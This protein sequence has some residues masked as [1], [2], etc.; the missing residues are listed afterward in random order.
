[1][2]TGQAIE[3]IFLENAERVFF[4][5]ADSQV[6]WSYR[7]FHDLVIRMAQGL[8]SQGLGRGDRF[9]VL[10]PNSADLASLYFASVLL[11]TVIMPVNPRLHPHEIEAILEFSKPKL[12]LDTASTHTLLTPRALAGIPKH[13]NVENC[14][15]AMPSLDASTLYRQVDPSSVFLVTFTSGTTGLPK[16]VAHRISSIFDN[17]R[18]LNE[19]M[20]FT[21]TDSFLHVMPMAYMA[22]IL[23]TLI[24]PFLAQGS[25][26]SIPPF[27]ART[28]LNFWNPVIQNKVTAM[29]LAPTMIAALLKMD[30]DSRAQE[31][32]CTHMKAILVG[33]APLSPQ[34]KNDFEKR[35]SATLYESYGLSELLF[36]TTN[37]PGTK[38]VPGSVGRLLSGIQI[39]L[40]DEEGK[41]LPLSSDGEIWITTP[42]LMAGYL[43]AETSE[44]TPVSAISWFPTGDIGHLDAEGNLLIT[45]RKKDLIIKGGLN[46]S[47]RAIE[48]VLLKHPA[49]DGAAVV[50]LKHDFYGEEIVAVVVMKKKHTLEENRASLTALCKEHLSLAAVPMRYVERD[51]LP[52]N[53]S[54][55]I[56][57]KTLV[58]ELASQ[59]DSSR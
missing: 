54:G 57:K 26:V 44:L 13:L 36:I 47:P 50:G 11:G 49:V 52:V 55:K 17:G 51:E 56:Q 48:E 8:S 5:N 30:R 43:N 1:M 58:E 53:A 2:I 23:N 18:L 45:G 16:G 12:L 38:Q 6:S 24:G 35:Y 42:H 9:A 28:V 39:Q 19:R 4:I 7:S 59:P 34:L 32:C 40:T 33:T 29:W 27:D 21:S 25:I 41:L 10:L 14:P 20:N 3:K 22:G 46:I 37:S 15:A 31:Y